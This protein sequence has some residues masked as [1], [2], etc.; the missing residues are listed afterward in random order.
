MSED[1]IGKRWRTVRQFI[2]EALVILSHPWTFP[3]HL[4]LGPAN[5]LG[6]GVRF[7]ALA[8]GAAYL[9]LAPICLLDGRRVT[10]GAILVLNLAFLYVNG[11]VFHLAL[12]LLGAHRATLR[13]TLGL[14]GYQA[15]MQMIGFLL[16]TY[17]IP[18]RYGPVAAFGG[19]AAELQQVA[20]AGQDPSLWLGFFLLAT[21]AGGLWLLFA[22]VP[23]YARY[24][25]LE[26]LGRTRVLLALLT[27]AAVT[28]RF[29]GPA[30]PA[31]HRIADV[32]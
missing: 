2:G 11:F 25:G 17:P 26:V 1:P 24:Y 28:S 21:A 14:Y 31:L 16:M 19:S 18:L 20:E 15:G 12:K 7:L 6:S 5:A 10:E 22:W 29:I 8:S 4:G 27:A 13:E 23:M 30:V 3:A 32:L 9:L